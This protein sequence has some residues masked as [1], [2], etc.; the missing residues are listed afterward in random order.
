MDGTFVG[1]DDTVHGRKGKSKTL[2]AAFG[3]N[4]PGLSAP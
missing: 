2:A 4:S 1:P 3:F